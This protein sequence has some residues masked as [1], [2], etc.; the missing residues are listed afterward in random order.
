MIT[1]I[2]LWFLVQIGDSQVSWVSDNSGELTPHPILTTMS[3]AV[4]S[5]C[6]NIDQTEKQVL[7]PLHK[8]YEMERYQ[9][10]TV[11]YQ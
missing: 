6:K 5:A 1:K 9:I 2:P 8:I 7:S 11:I 10:I 4:H 3:R